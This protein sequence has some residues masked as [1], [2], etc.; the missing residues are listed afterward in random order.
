[1]KQGVHEPVRRP[2]R[3]PQVRDGL[4]W[5]ARNHIVEQRGSLPLLSHV[6]YH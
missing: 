6:F 2:W 5:L 4:R 1:M 3:V